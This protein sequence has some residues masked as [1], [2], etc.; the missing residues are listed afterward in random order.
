M[1]P[2]NYSFICS[3]GGLFK[4]LSDPYLYRRNHPC[5]DQVILEYEQSLYYREHCRKLS[6]QKFSFN[7]K[8]DEDRL[9]YQAKCQIGRETIPCHF[10]WLLPGVP[11]LKLPSVF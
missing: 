10:S 1:P 8:L 2:F 3:K 6:T 4:S 9:S 5:T 7:F 11:G